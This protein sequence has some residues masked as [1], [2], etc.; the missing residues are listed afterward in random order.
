MPRPNVE[1]GCAE[2]R[3]SARATRRE[4]IGSLCV[5]S[6]AL[7]VSSIVLLAGPPAQAQGTPKPSPTTTANSSSAV[8][9]ETKEG[10]KLKSLPEGAPSTDA[11]YQW[12]GAC[13]NGYAQGAGVLLA[14]FRHPNVPGILR[15][16][17][18]G[19]YQAGHLT[20]IWLALEGSDRG[21]PNFFKMRMYGDGKLVWL[22]GSS[23]NSSVRESASLGFH[24]PELDRLGTLAKERNLAGIPVSE[25]ADDIDAWATDP[26]WSG[27]RATP[28]RPLAP[29]GRLTA[30]QLRP[31]FT[32]EGLRRRFDMMKWEVTYDE[33]SA[34][35]AL[36]QGAPSSTGSVEECARGPIAFA[37]AAAEASSKQEPQAQRMLMLW[38]HANY[39]VGAAHAGCVDM[40]FIT[41]QWQAALKR[42]PTGQLTADDITALRS[43]WVASMTA[44]SGVLKPAAGVSPQTAGLIDVSVLHGG[45]TADKLTEVLSGANC[46]WLNKDN[47]NCTGNVRFGDVPVDYA[48]ATLGLSGTL[49]S[50]GL[51]ASKGAPAI[52]ALLDGA[53]GPRSTE[54]QDFLNRQ[55]VDREVGRRTDLE[56]GPGGRLREVDVRLIGKVEQQTVYTRA[57]HTWN[58]NM[59]SAENNESVVSISYQRCR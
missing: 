50:L 30:A 3:Q 45:M 38:G 56:V 6:V 43:A 35:L 29:A 53:L 20:G 2:R 22:R 48:Q 41:R 37:D 39:G 13:P 46:R 26:A 52:A 10:C 11:E 14:D 5:R 36:P 9:A 59:F 55:M 57:R 54:M 47:Y 16:H 7:T 49:R 12:S 31:A 51:G 21:K 4:W 17:F 28:G 40:P 34:V 32:Q 23:I 42:R 24:L 18:K 25:L 15:A 33:L 58:S 1:L 19:A 8:V 44:C 27:L